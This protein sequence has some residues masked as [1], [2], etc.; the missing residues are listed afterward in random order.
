MPAGTRKLCRTFQVAR[1]LGR[2]PASCWDGRPFCHIVRKTFGVL[3]ICTNCHE[4]C[5]SFRL[6]T[7][8]SIAPSFGLHEGYCSFQVNTTRSTPPSFK[9]ETFYQEDCEVGERESR[10]KE[11]EDANAQQVVKQGLATFC[12]L[13]YTMYETLGS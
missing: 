11:M 6:N 12:C 13:V 7:M 2:L 4:E 8:Q 1:F 10:K 5:C 3:S 9:R